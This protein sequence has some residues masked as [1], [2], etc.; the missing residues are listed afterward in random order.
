[1]IRSSLRL[2]TVLLIF[3]CTHA[4]ASGAVVLP[5]CQH[6]AIAF[7]NRP[8]QYT[9]NTLVGVDEARC[10]PVIGSS[11]SNLQRLI[12][13]VQEGKSWAA[14]YLAT[15][16]TRLDGGNL[17]DSLIALGQFSDHSMKRFL[18][19]AEK[20]QISKHELADA[21]TM[22]PLSL[23]DDPAAQLSAL[24]ARRNLVTRINQDDLSDQKALALKAIDGFIAQIKATTPPAFGK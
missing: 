8:T 23:S 19:F 13:S 20:G 7:L 5:D 14:Q 24:K 17:E 18:S 1:M 2:M 15:N 21:V 22:L 10:W 4:Q 9:F 16:L 12:N 11:N 3:F 6:E